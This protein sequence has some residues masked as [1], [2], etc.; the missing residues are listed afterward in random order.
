M[1]ETAR[2]GC[3]NMQPDMQ[4]SLETVWVCDI[5]R[6]SG[7][8]VDPETGLERR[9]RICHGEGLLDHPPPRVGHDPFDGLEET[10]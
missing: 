8:E 5:C 2:A 1:A 3:M 10:R 7:M 9:C 6:S 4:L